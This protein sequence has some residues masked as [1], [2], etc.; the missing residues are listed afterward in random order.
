MELA[1]IIFVTAVFIYGMFI[2]V[3]TCKGHI[4]TLKKKKIK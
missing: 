3:E 2:G 1:L 4:D